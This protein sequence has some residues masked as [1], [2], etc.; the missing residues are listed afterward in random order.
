MER[1]II[2]VFGGSGFV[3][4]HLVKR[5]A[6]TGAIIRVAVRDIEAAQFLKPLGEIG[7]I[8]PLPVDVKRPDLVAHAVADADA[9]VNLVGILSPWGRNTFDA[10]HAQG[11]ETVAKAAAA[12]GVRTL[13]HMSALGADPNSES[14]YAR[15]KADGEARVRAAFPDA[16]IVRPS[17]IFGPEDGFFNLFAGLAR[18]SPV[19]PLVGG[20]LFP[21]VSFQGGKLDIDFYGDGGTQFQPVYVGDVAEAMVRGITDP[22]TKGR[23]FELGGPGVYSFKALL[24]MMLAEIGRKR[25]IMPL[26]FALASIEAWFLEKLPMP[27]L[28]RDQV[29]LLKTDN[30]VKEGA[31]TLADLG[32]TPTSV[33][34]I[35][36]TYLRRYRPTKRQGLRTA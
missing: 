12:A 24:D 7:Q 20:R 3:G 2:T 35:L 29:T 36:P 28:T 21:A 33:K 10:V 32:I 13:V 22:T 14:Q 17:V 34:L 5:L 6:D 18:F 15:T 16:M 26:P 19:L 30:V 23:T 8:I 11:A 1:R 27:L 25:L 31:N 4:R 9:V